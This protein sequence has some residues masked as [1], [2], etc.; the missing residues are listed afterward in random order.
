MYAI[1]GYYAREYGW[2][3]LAEYDN[4]SDAKRDFAEYAIAEPQYQHRIVKIKGDNVKFRV[5]PK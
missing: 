1:E 3:G 4:L 5:Y 2:E